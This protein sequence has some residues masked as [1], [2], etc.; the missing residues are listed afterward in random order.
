MNHTSV[1]TIYTAHTV[2][3]APLTVRTGR[4]NMINVII[5]LHKDLVKGHYVKIV[6]SLKDTIYYIDKTDLL[7][8]DGDIL[9]VYRANGKTFAVNCQ[10][11]VA[12]CITE[13]II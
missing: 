12:C 3:T 10:F 7:K 2:K 5:E 4:K 6:T 9:K 13:V 11:V 8:Q 1:H